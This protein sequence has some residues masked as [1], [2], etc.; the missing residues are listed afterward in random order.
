MKNIPNRREREEIT[1]LSDQ[2]QKLEEKLKNS[3]QRNKLTIERLKKQVAEAMEKHGELREERD[4][5][6]FTLRGPKIPDDEGEQQEGEQNEDQEENLEEEKMSQNSKTNNTHVNFYQPVGDQDNQVD[7]NNISHSPHF[8]SRKSDMIQMNMAKL[9][10][11][12]AQPKNTHFDTPPSEVE[13]E[14]S[15]KDEEQSNEELEEAED[16]DECNSDKY[17]MKFLDKYHNNRQENR[18]VVQEN[19]GE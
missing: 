10:G 5:V 7:M 3:D 4:S 2:L 1:K 14:V 11:Y 17:D 15:E 12:N 9:T 13:E 18:T 6:A 19:I 8:G 16:D